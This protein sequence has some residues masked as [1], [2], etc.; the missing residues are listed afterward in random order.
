MRVAL[1]GH[2][3]RGPARVRD[4]DLAVRGIGVDRVLQHLHLADGA[5]ALEMRGAIEYRDTSGVVASVFQATQTL[6]EDG[7]YV[8]FSDGSDDAAH[9]TVSRISG[10]R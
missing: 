7:H 8:P 5:Q 10:G 2:A 9:L 3:V 4:A 6:H 1:R